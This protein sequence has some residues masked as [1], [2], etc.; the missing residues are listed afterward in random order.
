MNRSP[1]LPIVLALATFVLLALAL[2]PQEE[3]TAIIVVAGRDLG[4]GAILAPSD[5]K[6]VTLPADQ[7]PADAVGDVA[8]LVGESLSVVRYSGEPVTPRHLGP[9]VILAPDER[10]IAVRVRADTGLAGLLRPGMTVG[11]VAT[12][13]DDMTNKVYAKSTLEN[14]RVLY[15][16]PSFQ[17]RSPQTVVYASGGDGTY[18]PPPPAQEP[19]REGVIVLAAGTLPEPVVYEDAETI[20]RRALAEEQSEAAREGEA[21]GEPPDVMWA[22]PVELLAALNAADASFTLVLTP[23]DALPYTSPGLDLARMEPDSDS[24]NPFVQR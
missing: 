22:V 6:T 7:A 21:E 15:V 20:L 17:A 16:P 4:A 2:W 1:I 19:V 10:G 13:R 8:L 24:N 23:D 3:P 9:A 11:V 14:L 5:L 12:L 18:A